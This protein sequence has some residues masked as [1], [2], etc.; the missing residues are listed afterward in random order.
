MELPKNHSVE[1]GGGRV[2]LGQLQ[3]SASETDTKITI[4]SPLR[5]RG[6]RG[7][8]DSPKELLSLP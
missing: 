1:L 6:I 7:L 4:S 3:M 2:E 5:E 8:T